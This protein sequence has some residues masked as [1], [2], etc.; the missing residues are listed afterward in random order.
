MK[1]CGTK[2]PAAYARG[3]VVAKPSGVMPTIKGQPLNPLEKAKRNN[4]IPGYKAGGKVKK[5]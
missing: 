1:T 2:K 5:C 3:G 4:G